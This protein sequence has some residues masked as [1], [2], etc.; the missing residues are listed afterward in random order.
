[1]FNTYEY[2][3]VK[4]LQKKSP[5][6]DFSYFAAGLEALGLAGAFGFGTKGALGVD[7]AL[8]LAGAF[9]LGSAGAFATGAAAT[10]ASVPAG[11]GSTTGAGVSTLYGV[12]TGDCTG[13][14]PNK[15]SLIFVNIMFSY[16]FIY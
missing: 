16:A 6:R 2:L 9:G 7:S 10:D 8:G 11:K 13:S 5:L 15:N 3:C 1:V 14:L 12:A 4:L